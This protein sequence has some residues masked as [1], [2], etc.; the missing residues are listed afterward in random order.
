LDNNP[1]SVTGGIE[2][3]QRNDSISVLVKRFPTEVTQ[4]F[5]SRKLTMEWWQWGAL[6]LIVVLVFGLKKYRDKTMR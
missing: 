2:S 6:V 1:G 4:L 5:S 3:R